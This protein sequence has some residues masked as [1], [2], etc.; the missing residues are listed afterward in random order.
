MLT[1]WRDEYPLNAA[2]KRYPKPYV[3]LIDGIVMGGGVGVSVHGSH[4]SRATASRSRCPRSASASS[5]TSA[6][7]WFL[8][9][10][11]GELGTWCALTGDRLEDR[12]RGRG[13]HRD[14]SR[15]L[16]PLRRSDR[17]AVRQRLG[18][19]DAR[20][21]C[22]AAG[23]GARWRRGVRRSTGCSPAIAWRIFC[24]GSMRRQGAD[25]EWA[26]ATAATIRAKS[27]LSLKIALA[28]V[29]RGKRLV[30]RGLHAL[31]IPHRVAH[32]LRA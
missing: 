25:R 29:R 20:G 15:A 16:G 4:A 18:R 28:Q 21:L 14:A 22:G 6:R 19:R 32:R 11:P 10:M 17:C 23:R 3:A 26:A 2:I 24:S 13:R 27:P 7:T 8:P 12:G 30:V 1:F 9:R 5:P 31:R